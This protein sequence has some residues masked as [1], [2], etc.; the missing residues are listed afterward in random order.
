M[1][2]KKNTFY[3][4]LI[5]CTVKSTVVFRSLPVQYMYCLLSYKRKQLNWILEFHFASF[6]P[7]PYTVQIVF[8]HIGYM[9]YWRDRNKNNKFVFQQTPSL[10]PTLSFENYV[11]GVKNATFS[12]MSANLCCSTRLLR[13][14]IER[15]CFYGHFLMPKHLRLRTYGQLPP[16]FRTYSLSYSLWFQI[17]WKFINLG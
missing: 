17:K 4:S 9:N 6:L 10:P 13:T 11:K 12:D 15:M 16:I 8:Y 7:L 14:L 3:S 2:N 5:D 1:I